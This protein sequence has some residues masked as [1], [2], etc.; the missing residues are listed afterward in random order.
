V[1]GFFNGG[2]DDLPV[3]EVRTPLILDPKT[4]ALPL[5]RHVA[6]LD[7]VR[8]HFVDDIRFVTSPSRVEIW[9]H[10]ETAT[11]ELRSVV[12]VI[13]V[14]MGGSF[15]TNKIDPDDIDLVYWC[16]DIEL[17]NVTDI[18]AMGLLHAFAVNSIRRDTGL[19]VDTRVCHWHLDP[20]AS[21]GATPR[22]EAYSAQR[23]FWD[24]FWARMRSG[25]KDQPPQMADALPRRGYFEVKLDGFH[26]I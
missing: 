20:N 13:C 19:R 14:W 10:F 24:D 3:A 9:N 11:S 25:S 1:S 5:G 12:P 26:G 22:H 2:S 6:T 15:L 17:N 18:G 7:E 8:R 21:H 16:H 23:G 4:G